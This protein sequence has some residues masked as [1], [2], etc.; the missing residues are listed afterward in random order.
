MARTALVYDPLFLAHRVSAYHPEQPA[1]LEVII[2]GLEECG[3]LQKLIL[4]KPR[5][6]EDEEL[7]AV[8][9]AEYVQRLQRACANGEQTIDSPDTEICSDSFAAAKLAAGAAL[10]AA[11]AIMQGAVDN[12]FCAVRPPGHHAVRARAMG[13]CLFNNVAVAARYLQRAH[14]V[15]RILIVDWDVHHGNG[16]QEAFYGDDSV[17]YF[18]VH[19]FP[20]YPGTGAA[21]EKGSGV[22]KGYTINVPLPPGSDDAA[23]ERAFKDVLRPAGERLSPEFVLISAGFDPHRSDALGDMCVTE[24][25]FKTMLKVVLEI[26]QRSCGGRLISVLEGGYNL[27]ALRTCVCDHVGMLLAA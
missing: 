3:L 24:A 9:A 27:Q 16:T 17:L 7:A 11:D 20:H 5:K 1:R 19:Q 14:G 6:A 12:A 4:L 10:V 13:F 2:S 21:H 26:A 18:S 15:R 22:G 25:G 23:Y 8:H